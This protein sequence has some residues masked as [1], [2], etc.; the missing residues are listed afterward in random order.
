M[1]DP[2]PNYAASW[3]FLQRFHP[4]RLIVVTGITLDK[5]SIPTE[6]FGPDQR[7]DF[8]KWVAAC[9]LM[10]ANIYF[11]VGEPM[12]RATKKL[13]R[14]DIKA[15]HYLH[16]DI[17]PRTGEDH[18]SEK[19]R[20]LALLRD[21]PGGLPKPTCIVYSG[22]GYQAYWQLSEALPV[23]GVM[24]VAEDLKRYNLQIERILGADNCH[25]VSR[26]MRVPGT[27][28]VPDAKKVKKGRAPALSQ[29]VE[30]HDDRVY[31]VDKFVKATLVQS[32]VA[33]GAGIGDAPKIKAPGNVRRLA[34]VDDLGDKVAEKCKQCIVNGFVPDDPKGQ[35]AGSPDHFPSRSERLLWVV[36]E[37]TRA[38]IDNDTIYGVITDPDFKISDSVL[39]KGAGAERYALRQIER[40]AEEAVNPMLREL[41]DKHAVIENFGGQCV[42]VEEVRDELLNRSRLTKQDFSNFRN[43]YMNRMVVVGQKTT[44][45]GN[46]VDQEMPAG[47]WWLRHTQRRQYHKVVFAP[48][49]DV[50]G[51]YNL[52]RGF[53]CEARPGDCTLYLNHIRDI[54]CGG[55]T[56]YY[57]WFIG[58]M[59][60]CVQHPAQQGESA[61]ILQGKQ[62]CG[63][64][65]VPDLFGLLFARHYLSINRPEHLVGQFNAH[66]RDCV[67][68]FA[69]EAFFAGNKQNANALKTIITSKTL[70]IEAKGV[71]AE[72]AANCVHLMMASN[73]EWVVNAD[74]G[75]RRNFV[76]NVLPDKIG[77]RAYFNAM[78]KQMEEEGGKEDLL[79]Y[80]LTYDLKA[81]K[82]DKRDVPKTDALR[83]QQE[84]SMPWDVEAVVYM[85]TNGLHADAVLPGQPDH[86]RPEGANGS[87]G[88]WEH[89][90]NVLQLRTEGRKFGSLKFANGMKPWGFKRAEPDEKGSVWTAPP[91]PELRR[92]IDEHTAKAH[93][94]PGGPDA[95][96]GW[97]ASRGI[98]NYQ[99]AERDEAER[100]V[101]EA[102]ALR[103]NVGADVFDRILRAG[104]ALGKAGRDQL[105]F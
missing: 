36:C 91:L 24:E 83:D 59:A 46:T 56:D 43:R 4:G 33:S 65:L 27:I 64:T 26:I 16:V 68:L 63:K 3:D 86:F 100:L 12:A 32:G 25:D 84:R 101:K 52:W 62:G 75:D 93:D 88:Q 35:A 95:H 8:L 42:V 82:W 77:D 103:V 9:A 21:P 37:L 17:D 48:G 73:E 80:L 94:W 18:E 76:L 90:R 99:K 92:K 6:T 19:T 20:I 39:D 58:W 31:S 67:L 89:L 53:G 10:P 13:E 7:G 96:W 34:H 45:S 51:A 14:T 2:Q 97:A 28:N 11:S 23:D 87:V 38:N 104:I 50:A 22:G 1:S 74:Y 55:I 15:V 69:D 29:V 66:L 47:E 85:A 44:K 57:N 54:V 102:T 61:I 98:D 5:K 41:N 70:N 49:H 81:A 105:P 40:A 72:Q 78:V 60:N 71:D 79:H 30:W